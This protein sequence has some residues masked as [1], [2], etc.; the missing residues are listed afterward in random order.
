MTKTF[1]E[2]DYVLG[3]WFVPG[4]NVDWLCVL[5]REGDEWKGHYRFRYYSP[6]ED[7]VV[8]TPFSG[9]DEKSWYSL[10]MKGKTEEMVQQDISAVADRIAREWRS[11]VDFVPVRGNGAAVID[12]L[13]LRRW[14]F[15]QKDLIRKP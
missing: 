7:P 5:W 11:E 14:A 12:A 3:V 13:R 1:I 10:S 6:I 9:L 15:M 2:S 8:N 4:S